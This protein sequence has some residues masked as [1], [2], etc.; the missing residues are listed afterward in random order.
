MYIPYKYAY[1][2]G[3][4]IFFIPWILLYHYRK[5]LRKEM[6][7]M[8]I[9]IGVG[10]VVTAYLWWTVD[11]WRPQTVTGTIVGIEDFLIG[12]SNGGIA[13]VIYEEVFKKRLYKRK[14]EHTHKAGTTALIM[15]CFFTI[16]TLFYL[17]HSTS[18][19]ASAIGMILPTL[20]LIYFRKDLILTSLLNGLLMV[21]VSL[22]M[23]YFWILFSPGW[24]EKTYLFNHLT[25]FRITGIPLE[26]IVFYFLF[27]LLIAPFYEYW[28][29]IRLRNVPAHTKPNRRKRR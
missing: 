12:F 13:V 26:D 21:F 1:F 11:W 18:F 16:F 3:T 4:V 6:W 19:I 29:G 27:G 24:I 10:S 23:Y 25:G 22:P 17:F 2:A 14:K 5:D 9:L 7:V 8:G 28:Q 20:C 15:L